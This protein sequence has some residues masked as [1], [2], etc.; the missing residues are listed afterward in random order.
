[1]GPRKLSLSRQTVD[2]VIFLANT[3]NQKSDVIFLTSEDNR[4]FSGYDEAK[5]TEFEA[6]SEFITF[7]R[8]LTDL[9]PEEMR[10][11]QG[12]MYLGRGDFTTTRFWEDCSALRMH[13]DR[14]VEAA[15][16]MS[17]GRLIDYLSEGFEKLNRSRLV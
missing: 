4:K 5:L 8:F 2:R 9:G 7:K 3:L 15:H 16:V 6:T 12:L 10:E 14:A 13:S 17:K 11:L 1:M